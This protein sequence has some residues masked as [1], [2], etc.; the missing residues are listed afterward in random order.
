MC[1]KFTAMGRWRKVWNFSQP[2]TV[3]AKENDSGD[4]EGGDV[5]TAA[6]EP[7]EVVTYTPGRVIPVIVFDAEKREHVVVPMRWGFPDPKNWK[8]PRPIHARSETVETKHPFKFPFRDGKRGI[9]VMRTFNEGK[10][11][12]TPR[13]RKFTEQWTIDPGDGVPRGF[14]FVWDRFVI[15]GLPAPMLA[16]VMVTVPAS[17]LVRTIMEG[18]PD[19]RMPAI[20]EDAD[21]ATWLGENDFTLEQAKTVL[22]T[23]EGV[24]WKMA[25]EPKPPKERS[26]TRARPK[27]EKP[28]RGPSLF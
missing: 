27:P 19:P 11:L 18:D 2:L 4:S 20:L 24:N 3:P 23:M 14:A 16:C 26:T 17:A 8:F 1:G 7:D 12:V 5:A 28:E 10:E 21:W 13:G 9:V 6:T 22:R 15:E 25:P